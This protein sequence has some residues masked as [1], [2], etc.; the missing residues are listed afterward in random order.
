M[1]KALIIQGKTYIPTDLV[2]P[3]SCMQ[4]MQTHRTCMHCSVNLRPF[5]IQTVTSRLHL[6]RDT[7]M[8]QAALRTTNFLTTW[9]LLILLSTQESQLLLTYLLEIPTFLSKAKHLLP[10]PTSLTSTVTLDNSPA[11]FLFLSN[12]FK[13][14]YKYCG[15][16]V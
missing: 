9:T 16:A 14:L 8:P 15:A 10:F 13:N 2:S 11:I 12:H 5:R 6:F 4:Q 3:A 7:H 1:L